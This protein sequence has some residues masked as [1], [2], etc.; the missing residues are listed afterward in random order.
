MNFWN[1]KHYKPESTEDAL[2]LTIESCYFETADLKDAWYSIPI[3]ENYQKY[4]KLFWKGEY[5]QDIVF[6][7]GFSPSVRVFTTAFA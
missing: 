7:Y 5:Y 3:H 6:R 4:L 1:C 2:D